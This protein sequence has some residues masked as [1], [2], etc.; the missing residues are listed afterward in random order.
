VKDL[1]KYT[2]APEILDSSPAL[3]SLYPKK[4]CKLLVDYFTVSQESKKEIQKKAIKDF[5]AGLPKLKLLGDLLRARKL[6]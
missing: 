2:D 1:K 6:L 3:F 5:F 4:V